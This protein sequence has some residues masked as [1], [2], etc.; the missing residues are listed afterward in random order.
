MEEKANQMNHDGVW[1]WYAENLVSVKG[2]RLGQPVWIVEADV[3]QNVLQ[4]RPLNSYHT[5][6]TLNDLE[7]DGFWKHFRKRRKCW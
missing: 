2:F 4:M 1:F 3:G 7:K 6:Q 5:I